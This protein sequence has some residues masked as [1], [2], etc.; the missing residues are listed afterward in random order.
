MTL[1]LSEIKYSVRRIK[2]LSDKE[3]LECARLFSENYGYYREDSPF[4]AGK[5]IRMTDRFFKERY[6]R[7]DISIATARNQDKLIGQAIYVRKNY[8]RL[9]TMTW[10]LQLVV[11]EEYQKNGIGS[12]LLYS[13][14]GMS[15]DFAWGLATA[16]PCTVKAL[17]GA[18]L[19]KCDPAY[20][21]KNLE[22]IKKLAQEVNFAGPDDY[23]VDTDHSLINTGFYV[24]N[25]EYVNA[26]K[27]IKGWKLGDIPAGYEWLAFTFRE[28]KADDEKQKKHFEQLMEF[29]EQKLISF[30]NR[31]KIGSHP[32]AKGAKNEIDHILKVTGLQNGSKVLDVG[33]GI[34]RHSFEL[35]E[36]GFFVKGLDNASRHINEAKDQLAKH[37]RQLK[38]EFEEADIRGYKSR[39]K[40]DM[41]MALYD[42]IGSYPDEKNNHL[43]LSKM[44]KR[45]RRGGYLVI[46]VM[47]MELT[48]SIV[49]KNQKGNVHKD[50]QMLYDLK[51]S[52]IMQDSGNIFN[53]DYLV[54][55]EKENVVYRKEQ[56]RDD[57]ELPA[58]DIVRDRRYRMNEIVTEIEKEGF[59]IV[60][61]RY[62]RAGHFDENLSN[63]DPGAKEILIIGKRLMA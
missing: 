27:K 6:N 57:S 53:P 63:T 43:I 62:V 24:D 12:T 33:C 13:I 16:N 56:F 7:P 8:D 23:T 26:Y 46:S 37:Q 47:N 49:P 18:T 14:W 58:E 9:G 60:D 4:K 55:D 21:S 19:R 36:R 31:M 25:K 54:I 39:N 40:Y 22:Y 50:I 45:V 48:E 29:S 30:Y 3:I 15:N 32:W 61:K 52:S 5:R 44:A 10:V 20:I 17:E 11:A 34:G 1:D 59:E 38:M 28:Q 51:P 42:V 2:D 41:V 35:A